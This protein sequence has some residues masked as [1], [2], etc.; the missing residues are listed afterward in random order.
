MSDGSEWLPPTLERIQAYIFDRNDRGLSEA[1]REVVRVK[2]RQG[3][4]VAV[5]YWN[6]I[7]KMDLRKVEREE[8]VQE[9]RKKAKRGVK[10]QRE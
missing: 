4:R 10:R 7:L 8:A 1:I 9:Q 6:E 5:M 3:S 2:A